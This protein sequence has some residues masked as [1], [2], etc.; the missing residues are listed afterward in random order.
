M[1]G[2]GFDVQDRIDALTEG[3]VG[4]GWLLDE[5]DAFLQGEAHRF[6]LIEGKP[7]TGKSALAARIVQTRDIHAFHFATTREGGTLDPIAFVRSL[8]RQLVRTLPDFGEQVVQQPPMR[9]ID[10]SQEIDEVSGGRVYGVYIDKFILQT[11]SADAA[12]QFLIREPLSGW[13]ETRSEEERV[14]ILIDA[15]DEAARLD[16]TPNIVGLIESARDLPMQVR[17]VLTTRP[18]GP[19]TVEDDVWHIVLD[20]AEENLKD[21]SAYV[22]AWLEDHKIRAAL[23]SDEV[24]PER[25]GRELL[26]RSEGNF[27]YLKYVLDDLARDLGAGKPLKSLDQL[28]QGLD[29]VYHEFLERELERGKVKWGESHRPVLGVLAVAQEPLAF[30][31]LAA[32]SGVTHQE[33]NDVRRG[34]RQLLGEAAG[35]DDASYELY[36]TSFADFLTDRARSEDFWVDPVRYHQQV[37]DYGPSRYG[38]QWL[39]WRDLDAPWPY[40]LRHTPAHLSAT[41]ALC[42]EQGRPFDQHQATESLVGLA[43][44]TPYRDAHVVETG[45]IPAFQ[46]VVEDAL[47]RA[48]EDPTPLGSPLLVAAALGLVKFRRD[49]LAP[50]HIFELAAEGDLAAAERLLDL[51]AIEPEWRQAGLLLMSWLADE[52]NEDGARQVLKRVTDA[53]EQERKTRETLPALKRL[54]DRMQSVLDDGS[55]AAQEPPEKFD[56]GYPEKVIAR[57]G[58]LRG[59][60][61]IPSEE[62]YHAIN[63]P[64]GE[65]SAAASIRMTDR[66]SHALVAYAV[67]H[68]EDPH[69]YLRDQVMILGANPYVQYRNR[70]LWPTLEA[71]LF[72]TDPGWAQ[73]MVRT[74]LSAAMAASRLEFTEGLPITI[75]ACRAKDDGKS[76]AR[77]NAL[78]DDLEEAAKLLTEEES[79]GDVWGSYTRRLAAMA[80]GYHLLE[81]LPTVNRLLDLGAKLHFGLA[82]FQSPAWLTL[83]EAFRVCGREADAIEQVLD[84]ARAS[85]HN[86]Q[87][88]TF[89][90]QTTARYNALGGD[91]WGDPPDGFNVADAADAFCRNPGEP[92]FGALHLVDEAYADRDLEVSLPLPDWATTGANTL[93]ALSEIY[94]V[95]VADLR[96]LN[97]GLGA[98]ENLRDK[99]VEMV[100]IPDPG[101]APLL[102]ALFAAEALVSPDLPGSRARAELIR[103]LVPL[104][105]ANPIALDTVLAR[106]V[107]AAHP[108]A[109][110]VLGRIEEVVRSARPAD[111]EAWQWLKERTSK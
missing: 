8:S 5:L 9:T 87:D 49:K 101:F 65:S 104:A 53:L 26:E 43:L 107:L 24:D 20:E 11:P 85:A 89:C 4:R 46:R 91:W 32:L 68:P 66:D 1:S 109:P 47:R 96:R 67:T 90:V 34:V 31:A 59:K 16:R 111:P 79:A 38:D 30:G 7:G 12:F 41:A 2:D 45:D 69:N 3:F 86:V 6:F 54:R 94:G 110:G 106:Y 51:F 56:L 93:H 21:L 81:D 17:W 108:F 61:G 62:T 92:R 100:R 14:V 73:E 84:A 39:Y 23:A 36:H 22:T 103:R 60:I 50:N 78:R 35:E 74:I 102:A 28:P 75:L 29:R 19:L 64:P 99:G 18:A 58:Q 52:E 40:A 88:P 83:A 33:A 70:F 27:L 77:L 76:R 105:A 72:H 10:V 80:Q 15:L 82:G 95:P 63:L 44:S 71:A 98:D 42:R 25:L 37:A 97:P 13:A 48:A 57:L 55:W